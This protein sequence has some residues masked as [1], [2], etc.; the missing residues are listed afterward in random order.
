MQ[1]AQTP[2]IFSSS[3][4]DYPRKGGREEECKRREK[5]KEEGREGAKDTGSMVKHMTIF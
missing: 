3:F 1:I 5:E 4:L 2:F